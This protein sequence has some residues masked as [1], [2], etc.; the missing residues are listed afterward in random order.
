MRQLW[1]FRGARDLQRARE[2]IIAT[3]DPEAIRWIDT[4]DFDVPTA[5]TGAAIP[6]VRLPVMGILTPLGK[7]AKVLGFTKSKTAVIALVVALLDDAAIPMPY[8]QAQVKLLRDFAD[9]LRTRAEKATECA[10]RLPDPS[11]TPPPPRSS[12]ADII[13]VRV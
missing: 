1:R 5:D 13:G 6:K 9:K 8:H 4:W 10:A 11:G 12:L 2:A 3:G 7:L